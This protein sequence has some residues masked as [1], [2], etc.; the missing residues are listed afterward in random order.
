MSKKIDHL[1]DHFGH[2]EVI[3]SVPSNSLGQSQW[4]TRCSCGVEK[5]M[6]GSVLRR[7]EAKSCGCASKLDRSTPTKGLNLGNGREA[8]VDPD[9]RALLGHMKWY[10]RPDGYPT[11]TG[12]DGKKVLLHHMVMG[13]SSMFVDHIN[14]NKLDNR[15]CNLRW[16]DDHQ[17]Q[18]NRGKTK[19]LSSKYK[20]VTWDRGR[21]KAMIRA[22]G[23][24]RHIGRFHCETDAALAYNEAAK[25]CFGAYAA[26]NE[27]AP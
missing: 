11:T 18:M 24:T 5:I 20:G 6:R 21:W 10:M 1:G 2:L 12:P 25:K 23:R 4:L 7:G 9:V 16:V 8:I 15:R 14:R 22:A 19:G 17:N 13:K 27:I 26:L 3:A